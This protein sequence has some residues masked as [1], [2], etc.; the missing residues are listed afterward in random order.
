MTSQVQP[1]IRARLFAEVL[2]MRGEPRGGGCAPN[3]A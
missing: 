1:Q 2:E 3:V